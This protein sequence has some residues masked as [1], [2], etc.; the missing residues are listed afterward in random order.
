MDGRNSNSVWQ[1]LERQVKTNMESGEILLCLGES[2]EERNTVPPR[3]RKLGKVVLEDKVGKR[4]SLF[5]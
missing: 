1:K 4:S 5:S 3:I 2:Q